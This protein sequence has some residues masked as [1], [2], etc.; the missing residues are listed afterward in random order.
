MS[1]VQLLNTPMTLKSS[2]NIVGAIVLLA[3]N[4]IVIAA[5][6]KVCP[7]GIIAKDVQKVLQERRES[8]FKHCLSC[9]GNRCEL[10]DWPADENSQKLGQMCKTFFCTAI[11]MPMSTF[12]PQMRD[13]SGSTYFTYEINEKGRAENFNVTSVSGELSDEDALEWAQSLF[14]R[15][16]YEPVKIG[17]QTYVITNLRWSARIRSDLEF[18]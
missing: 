6:P 9:Q 16:K 10:K 13:M 7:R 12:A 3:I 15:R 18:R 1:A 17:D 4:S 2:A 8:T 5:E 11:K 14:K